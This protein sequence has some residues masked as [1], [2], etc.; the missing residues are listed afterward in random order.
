MA[1]VASSN[2]SLT[3]ID[4]VDNVEALKLRGTSKLLRADPAAFF[5]CLSAAAPELFAPAAG[6]AA[7]GP[8]SAAAAPGDGVAPPP[9]PSPGDIKRTPLPSTCTAVECVSP[10]RSRPL[11]G[12]CVC[13][14]LSP[15]VIL[16]V[17]RYPRLAHKRAP[18]ARAHT[19]TCAHALR[20]LHARVVL[21]SL[22]H[23]PGCFPLPSL[24][25][26]LP[27]CHRFVGRAVP[28]RFTAMRMLF[29][30]VSSWACGRV[31]AVHTGAKQS[32]LDMQA[33][34]CDHITLIAGSGSGIARGPLD[35]LFSCSSA[36]SMAHF[37][38]APTRQCVDVTCRPPNDALFL[39]NHPFL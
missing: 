27:P 14:S 16:T 8:V 25:V 18:C 38:K 19:L 13:V 10:R 7:A 34:L 6:A 32:L 26:Y 22:S 4:F 21:L 35:R 5:K 2:S 36:P 37:K 12:S 30:V 33:D 31:C 20:S 1:M 24:C 11:C 3:F 9:P 23:G 28:V 15:S 17:S 39:G 29:A